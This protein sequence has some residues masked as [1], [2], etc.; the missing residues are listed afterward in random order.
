M[1]LLY[2]ICIPSIVPLKNEWEEFV[3]SLFS[4]FLSLRGMYLCLPALWPCA[5]PCP[6]AALPDVHLLAVSAELS[7]LLLLLRKQLKAPAKHGF[8]S[9]ITSPDTELLSSPWPPAVPGC[10][11]HPKLLSALLLRSFAVQ[12]CSRA[13]WETPLVCFFQAE[14]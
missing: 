2:E 4:L 11:H 8:W 9:S 7:L 3:K 10:G 14:K 12:S 6:G 5:S 1:L 13:D